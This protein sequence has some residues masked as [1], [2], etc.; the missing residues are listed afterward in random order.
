[1]AKDVY[2]LSWWV[3]GMVFFSLSYL[4]V[5]VKS[6]KSTFESNSFCNSN[7]YCYTYNI[8]LISEREDKLDSI[9][10][11]MR[12]GDNEGVLN[13]LQQQT[14]ILLTNIQIR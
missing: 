4:T 7:L 14:K 3:G 13:S 5:L 1:M 2:P 10:D 12:Q 9:L 6:P 8:F 11:E